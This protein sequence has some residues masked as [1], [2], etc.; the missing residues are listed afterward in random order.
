MALSSHFRDSFP[1]L[2]VQSIALSRVGIQ[3]TIGA[4]KRECLEFLFWPRDHRYARTKTADKRLL[5]LASSK[6]M[7][8]VH[9]ESSSFRR[10]RINTF[11]I[12]RAKS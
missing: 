2:F 10:A 11:L 5:D 8:L 1:C 6:W 9:C 4:A 12:G 7:E 3:S